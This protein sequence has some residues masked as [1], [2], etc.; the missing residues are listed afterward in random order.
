MSYLIDG[1]RPVNWGEHHE[2]ICGVISRVHVSGSDLR[3][4]IQSITSTYIFTNGKAQ[5]GVS[6]QDHVGHGIMQ[7]FYISFVGRLIFLPEL[8]H[9]CGVIESLQEWDKSEHVRSVGW[10]VSFFND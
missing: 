9:V 1:N 8:V 5:I 4:E 7:L 6:Q 10:Q 3:F 2:V